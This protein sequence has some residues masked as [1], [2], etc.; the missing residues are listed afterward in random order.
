MTSLPAVEYFCLYA[1]TAILFDFFLQMTAFVA[2]LTMDANRQK[3]GK[4]DWCCCFTSKKYL[5]EQER[6]HQEGIQRGVTLPDSNGEGAFSTQGKH[7]LKTEV[8]QI[9][10]MGRFMK[11]KYSPFVLSAKGKAL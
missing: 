6:Q 10:P 7:D 9:S 1:A 11:D 4:I 5:Q 8:H 2:L 3:A